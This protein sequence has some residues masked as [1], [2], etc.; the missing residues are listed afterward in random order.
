MITRE[1]VCKYCGRA[2][3]IEVPGRD[4]DLPPS[5]LFR[6]LG[7]NPL[8]GH[9]HYRC[10]ACG[11]VLLVEPMA[12]LTTGGLLEGRPQEYGRSEDDLYA[13]PGQRR[14]SSWL[15]RLFQ[16]PRARH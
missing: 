2:G 1:I 10:P 7:H 16:L 4:E 6:F 13:L 5:S 14:R 8:S 9:M 3:R 15:G 11:I 12:M